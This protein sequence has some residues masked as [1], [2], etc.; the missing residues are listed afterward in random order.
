T[1]AHVHEPVDVGGLESGVGE[2]AFDGLPDD[3]L[4]GTARRLRHVGVA[5]TADRDLPVHVIEV[6]GV[7]PLV[8]IGRHG[9]Q[10]PLGCSPMMPSA[11]RRSSSASVLPS[12]SR[13]TSSL[14]WPSV[15]A[16]RR[17]HPS[18]L[19]ANFHAPAGR[20]QSPLTGWC[21]VSKKARYS[22][23]GF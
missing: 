10:E 14:C 11:R 1:H 5:H 23:C 20:R 9:A 21:S 8:G 18:W 17:I 12:S 6:V 22:S 2:R 16:G 7:T 13:N 19:L 3:L 15:G 4:G